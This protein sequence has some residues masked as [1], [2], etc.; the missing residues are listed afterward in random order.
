MI[1]P[2]R[3]RS[4]GRSALIL[5]LRHARSLSRRRFSAP[6]PAWWDRSG[7]AQ[8]RLHCGHFSRADFSLHAQRLL[9]KGGAS[10]HDIPSSRL[11]RNFLCRGNASELAVSTRARSDGKFEVLE[12]LP[13]A[14]NGRVDRSRRRETLPRSMP[15]LSKLRRLRQLA[16][17]PPMPPGEKA[18]RRSGLARLRPRMPNGIRG[19]AP[20]EPEP[21]LSDSELRALGLT[22]A[23]VNGRGVAKALAPGNTARTNVFDKGRATKPA[24]MQAQVDT[25]RMGVQSD[26]KSKH[27]HARSRVKTTHARQARASPAPHQ[28]EA[29]K[30]GPTEAVHS[31]SA[32]WC[33]NQQPSITRKVLDEKDSS[34][35]TPTAATAPRTTAGIKGVQGEEQGNHSHSIREA[36]V[37]LTGVAGDGAHHVQQGSA[38][39]N[40]HARM[41]LDLFLTG[42]S[43]DKGLHELMKAR[44]V[45]PVRGRAPCPYRNYA[46]HVVGLLFPRPLAHVSR[47]VA[48]RNPIHLVSV[49]RGR[50][51]VQ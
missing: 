47:H 32:D 43:A 33:R 51:T 20:L 46:N 36:A 18:A 35:S 7:V 21:V 13:S 22:E 16:P 2:R 31:L 12:E 45:M 38:W 44:G 15:N 30:D 39:K 41:N 48:E 4:L 23:T 10:A 5:P 34:I 27:K 17:R 11:L 49:V 6:L 25:E 8:F 26:V 37:N 19:E 29:V 14:A 40:P 9:N 28:A 50:A 1:A 42:L 3:S 24:R